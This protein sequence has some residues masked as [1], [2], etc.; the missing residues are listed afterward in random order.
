MKN[1]NM[2]QL[3]F[4]VVP[5]ELTRWAYVPSAIRCKI[6]EPDAEFLTKIL[7]ESGRKMVKN[8]LEFYFTRKLADK[9]IEKK[10]AV[11]VEERKI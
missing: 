2:V 4:M 9:L 10:I 5:D 8:G 7:G 6:I 3:N 1:K 11:K